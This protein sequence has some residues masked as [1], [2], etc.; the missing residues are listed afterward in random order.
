MQARCGF[1]GNGIRCGIIFKVSMSITLDC[2]HILSQAKLRE[3]A[4]LMASRSVPT[5]ISTFAC[6][7]ISSELLVVIARN[8][9]QI[10][11]TDVGWWVRV[12]RE[13][14]R[15]GPEFRFHSAIRLHN[16]YTVIERFAS[17]KGIRNVCL[18]AQVRWDV[19]SLVVVVTEPTNTIRF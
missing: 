9:S 19:L 1:T 12:E 17:S 6:L 10:A 3:I 11:G 13:E 16:A 8:P 2:R 14:T 18:M 5:L 15:T 4:S 7:N